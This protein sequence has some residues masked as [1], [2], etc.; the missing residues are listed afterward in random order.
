MTDAI[1][2]YAAGSLVVFSSGEY[3]DFGYN[4]HFVVLQRLT[5][6]DMQAATARYLASLKAGDATYNYFARPSCETMT[7]ELIRAGF[8]LPL[9]CTEIFTGD[10]GLADEFKA[11]RP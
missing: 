4:G 7:A 10:Y 11:V 2:D 5:L 8:L 1:H 9:Q 6:A 3:S